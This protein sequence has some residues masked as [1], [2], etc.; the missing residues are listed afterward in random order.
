MDH[1]DPTAFIYLYYTTE[2]ASYL[3]KIHLL[4]KKLIILNQYVLYHRCD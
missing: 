4:V 2:N 1:L 3:S